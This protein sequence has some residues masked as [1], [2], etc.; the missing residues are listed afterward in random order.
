[1]ITGA[2][3]ALALGE[4]ATIATD[5]CAL[6]SAVSPARDEVEGGASAHDQEASPAATSKV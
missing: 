4:L 5:A 6:A 3:L 2:T 1:M